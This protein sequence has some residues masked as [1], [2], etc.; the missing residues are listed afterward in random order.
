MRWLFSVKGLLTIALVFFS[1]AP[2]ARSMASAGRCGARICFTGTVYGSACRSRPSG[3]SDPGAGILPARQP[4]C[5][6]SAGRYW[7]DSLLLHGI[8]SPVAGPAELDSFRGDAADCPRRYRYAGPA[9]AG[10]PPVQADN[11]GQLQGAGVN[12]QSGL[13]CRPLVFSSLYFIPVARGYLVIGSGSLRLRGTV[14]LPLYPRAVLTGTATSD[15]KKLAHYAPAYRVPVS[16]A[17]R[18]G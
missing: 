18:R 1:S 12:R 5:W 6:E 8:N 14:D 4:V 11:Q 7:R 9:G 3:V 13:D 10:H 15:E 16:V 17:V 2:P